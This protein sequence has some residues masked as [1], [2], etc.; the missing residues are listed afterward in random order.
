MTEMTRAEKAKA[1]VVFEALA[2]AL[3]ME[4]FGEAA[5]E[6]AEGSTPSWRMGD[7]AVSSSLS[8]PAVVVEDR[9]AFTAY[10]QTVSPDDVETVVTTV[11]QIRPHVASALLKRLA[12]AGP[13]LADHE[14]TVIPGLRFEAGG[15][16]R[17]IS[18]RPTSQFKDEATRFALAVAAGQQQMAL[19]AM[20]G[21]V[22]EIAPAV[23][24]PWEPEPLPAPG[25]LTFDDPWAEVSV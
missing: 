20:D 3:R 4:L 5:I 9:A 15:E 14:G 16:L 11:T 17:S 12:K 7:V 1:V 8:A 19:P 2:E 6:H 24:A 21:S 13:P 23:E 22:V 18:I 25:P 10:M